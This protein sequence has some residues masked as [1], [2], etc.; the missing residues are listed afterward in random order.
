[1]AAPLTLAAATAEQQALELC[2]KLAAAITTYQTANPTANLKGL[3][4]TRAIDINNARATFSIVLPL[5][6]AGTTDGGLEID[7][8]A[9]L[10]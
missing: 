8:E 7:A 2:N 3:R 5:I 1:M 4:V 10:A 9:V 6:A